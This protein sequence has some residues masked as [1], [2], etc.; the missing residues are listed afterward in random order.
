[1]KDLRRDIARQQMAAMGLGGLATAAC[2]HPSAAI[3]S[4]GRGGFKRSCL[5][6]GAERVLTIGEA[7]RL[8]QSA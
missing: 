5:S 1:M 7:Q 3:I 8:F 4:D 2:P 6:C